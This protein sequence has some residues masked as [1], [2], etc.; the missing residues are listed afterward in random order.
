MKQRKQTITKQKM[1]HARLG[2]VA[3]RRSAG[4]EKLHAHHRGQG[5]RKKTAASSSIS[6][7]ISAETLVFFSFETRRKMLLLAKHFSAMFAMRFKVS[8]TISRLRR[9]SHSPFA[10]SLT[11]QPD[12]VQH[13]K[14][15]KEGGRA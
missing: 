14:D 9:F 5:Y 6:P 1:L 3:P 12:L 10:N 15:A 11:H 8:L 13:E 2:S 7:A 4:L